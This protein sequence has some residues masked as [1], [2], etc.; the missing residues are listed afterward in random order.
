MDTQTLLS[1]YA[2]MVAGEFAFSP[3][4]QIGLPDQL[5]AEKAGITIP[6]FMLPE[7]PKE[8]EPEAA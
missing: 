3:Y 1:L 5:L 6:D 7:E 2:A 8:E 4:H